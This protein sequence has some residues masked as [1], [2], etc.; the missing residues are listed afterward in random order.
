MAAQCSEQ[1]HFTSEQGW[2]QHD[3]VGGGGGCSASSGAVLLD[4]C[5]WIVI[6]V[7]SSLIIMLLL[8]LLYLILSLIIFCFIMKNST[9][10]APHLARAKG[11]HPPPPSKSIPASEI[12]GFSLR[13]HDTYV[14]GV[15]QHEVP[16]L[17]EPTRNVIFKFENKK[18][19]QEGGIFYVQECIFR[20]STLW[21]R[22]NS[23]TF[24]GLSRPFFSKF[25]NLELGKILENG[26]VSRV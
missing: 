14:K 22:W 2:I 13:T 24:P 19:Q 25:K 12:V 10:S 15:S 9:T 11:V 26:T 20:V 21:W 1:T 4:Y 16:T 23:R 17:C 8:K 5:I 3:L 18:N 7:H 6:V